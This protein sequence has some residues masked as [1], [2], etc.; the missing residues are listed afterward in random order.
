MPL[1]MAIEAM[2]I[3]ASGMVHL[4]LDNRWIPVYAVLV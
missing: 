2:R 3:Q 4:F 1:L